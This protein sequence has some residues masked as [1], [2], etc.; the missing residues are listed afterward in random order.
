VEKGGSRT[1]KGALRENS[2]W[3][4]KPYQGMGDEKRYRM[5]RQSRKRHMCIV[6]CRVYQE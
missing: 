3:R 6:T 4:V 1:T 5:R 2:A